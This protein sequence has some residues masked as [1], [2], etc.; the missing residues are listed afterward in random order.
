MSVPLL[1]TL[2]LHRRWSN[3]LIPNWGVKHL[4][5]LLSTVDC[6]PHYTSLSVT[7][8]CMYVCIVNCY[9]LNYIHFHYVI[10]FITYLTSFF[11][12]TPTKF[13]WINR[14]RHA[15]QTNSFTV[16]H[17]SQLTT[18]EIC[19]YSSIGPSLLN[20]KTQTQFTS[21]VGHNLLSAEQLPLCAS[22]R[23]TLEFHWKHAVSSR[24]LVCPTRK[25]LDICSGRINRGQLATTA[26][27]AAVFSN[28][29]RG[30]PATPAFFTQSQM[31]LAVLYCS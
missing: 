14:Q 1:W 22:C 16:I 17:T 9:L 4:S 25:P 28:A 11:P 26:A 19:T 5:L 30:N 7:I 8:L 31:Q 15:K 18:Q 6:L 12:N 13:S 27:F 29:Q 10:H 2:N 21:Q 20:T 24:S 23:N 3:F